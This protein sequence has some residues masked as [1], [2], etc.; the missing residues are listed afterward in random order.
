MN[1]KTLKALALAML[2]A[3]PLGMSAQDFLPADSLKV[4]KTKHSFTEAQNR[5]YFVIGEGPKEK[6]YTYSGVELEYFEPVKWTLSPLLSGEIL[7]CDEK[8]VK[9]WNPYEQDSGKDLYKTEEKNQI[10]SLAYSP[11]GTYIL[12]ITKDNKI[13][14]CV[15]DEKVKNKLKYTAQLAG[16]PTQLRINNQANV[17]LFVEGKNVEIFNLERGASRRV[18]EFAQDVI[19]INFSENCREFAVLF[20][21]GSIKVVNSSDLKDKKNFAS[22]MG[23]KNCIYHPQGKYLIVNTGQSFQM[24][25][26]LTSK[27]DYIISIDGENLLVLD[28]LKDSAEKEQLFFVKDSYFGIYP[29]DGVERYHTMDL[30]YALDLQ[31]GDWAKMRDGE[32][33]EDYRNRVNDDTRAQYALQL[34]YD[35]VSQ[36]AGNLINEDGARFGKYVE[37]EQAL[38]VDFNNIPTIYLNIP[39]A[40]LNELNDIEDIEFFNTIYGLDA[41]DE[42]EVIYTDARNKHTGKVYMYDNRNR[43]TISFSQDDFVPMEVIQ[44]ANLEAAKLE[45]MKQDIME[46]AKTQNLLTDHTHITVNTEVEQNEDADGNKILNYNVSYVYQVE[47]EFSERDDFKAGKYVASESN[48]ATQ[49]LAV[50]EKSMKED[51]AKYLDDCSK[52][53]INITGSADATPINGKLRYNGEYG[54][55]VNQLATQDGELTSM[56]VTKAAGIKSNEELALVRAIGVGE[57]LKQG[58]FNNTTAAPIEYKYNVEV[59]KEKGSSFRRIK[60]AL[61]FVDTFKKQLGKE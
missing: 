33:E 9:L 36:M 8:K 58:A 37:K 24:L 6:I 46:E 31:M 41:N 51:F 42:F 54:D 32:S 7:Y 11:D 14:K 20:A 57:Y 56:T 49:M 22:V 53:I 59:S 12:V 2:C 21:D 61:K 34:E 28:L 1:K 39:S 13:H 48:A 17:A 52:I 23:A 44:L 19:D 29:L 47:E 5:A 40:D 10:H 15:T 55:I 43:E 18:L 27:I 25:N 45:E 60:V 3:T 4:V 26:L 30:K 38:A 50:V 16:T 35:L